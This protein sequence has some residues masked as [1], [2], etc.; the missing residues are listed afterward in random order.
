MLV[1][2]SQYGIYLA[3]RYRLTRTVFRGLRF[4]QTGSALHYSICAVWWWGW[5]VL[6]LGFAYPFTRAA[7][8]R[9]KMRNTWYGD[10]QGRFEGKGSYLFVRGFLMWL[11]VLIPGPDH[12]VCDSVDQLVAR[13][14]RRRAAA[15]MCWGASR[16][17]ARA[18]PTRSCFALLA[19]TVCLV[20]IA[21]L[22]PAFHAMVMRWWI[23]G[24]RFGEIA[25]GLA[26]AHPRRL[27]RLSAL[28]RLACWCSR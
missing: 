5:T 14:A 26:S 28:Y 3:R 17:R 20:L 9:F 12:A 27:C 11:A 15:A 18:L 19:G 13:D 4:H 2:L 8:E 24:I 25:A 23:S 7:L 1:F 10:L 22:L 21:A 6:T 16:K